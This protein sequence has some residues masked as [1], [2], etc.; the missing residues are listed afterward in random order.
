[1][2][3]SF[4]HKILERIGEMHSDIKGI[5]K[6][7]DTSNGRLLKNEIKITD[8]EKVDIKMGNEIKLFNDKRNKYTRVYWIILTTTLVFLTNFILIKYLK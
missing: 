1:M 7:L 6:R 2:S 4:E 5:N 3:L 8:L